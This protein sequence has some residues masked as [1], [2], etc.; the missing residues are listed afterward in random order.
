MVVLLALASGT[1]ARDLQGDVIQ[2][3]RL[4]LSGG[5]DGSG[6]GWRGE[7]QDIATAPADQKHTGVVFTGV[8]TANKGIE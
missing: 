2:R 1:E 3:E 7:F 4:G 5:L 8:G 6:D